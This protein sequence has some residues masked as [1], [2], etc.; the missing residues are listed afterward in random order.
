MPFDAERMKTIAVTSIGPRCRTSMFLIFL[1]SYAVCQKPAD[2]RLFQLRSV[3]NLPSSYDNI[4]TKVI[5][6]RIMH[7]SHASNT[8]W[9]A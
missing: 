8:M 1:E 6:A 5:H 4:A 2:F 9:K 3:C 7:L